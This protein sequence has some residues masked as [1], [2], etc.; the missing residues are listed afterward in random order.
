[1]IQRRIAG[2]LFEKI[3]VFIM[4]VYIFEL[5]QMNL[6]CKIEENRGKT[7]GPY[8]KKLSILLTIFTYP[9]RILDRKQL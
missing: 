4:K 2:Y 1:M 6:F 9:E 5:R 3:K 7:F 8:G